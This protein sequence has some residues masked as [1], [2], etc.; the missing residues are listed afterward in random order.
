M[1]SITTLFAV[2]CLT[3]M[4]YQV[5][6]AVP[7]RPTPT[8]TVT[9]TI[10]A[11]KWFPEQ[12]KKG[13]PGASGSLGQNRKFPAHFEVQLKDV[14]VEIVRSTG[15]KSWDGPSGKVPEYRL[16]INSNDKDQLKTGM[17]IRVFNYHISGDEGGIWSRHEKVEIL[18][19]SE[20]APKK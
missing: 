17:R 7:M 20:P 11:A 5:S 14:N 15:D 16:R 10:M 3:V 9:G 8:V 13:V 6:L 4:I 19:T 18:S 12:M 2:L 1:K